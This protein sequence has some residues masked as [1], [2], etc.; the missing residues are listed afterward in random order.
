MARRAVAKVAGIGAVGEGGMLLSTFSAASPKLAPLCLCVPIVSPVSTSLS[1]STLEARTW[2]GTNGGAFR[3]GFAARSVKTSGDKVPPPPAPKSEWEAV[4]DQA[5]GGTYYWNRRTNETTA[6]GV[7]HPDGPPPPAAHG[8]QPA[9]GGGGILGGLGSMMAQGMAL[10]AGSEV[11]HRIMGGLMGGGGHA[12]PQQ[13][14]P[15]QNDATGWGAG[16][17]DDDD[18]FGDDDDGDGFDGGDW[19]GWE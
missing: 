18:G 7:P 5:S 3:R 8:G 10:G 2:G 1:T 16:E 12:P 9:G 6:V 14:P 11:G 17:F 19:G 4:T 13:A 15:Q